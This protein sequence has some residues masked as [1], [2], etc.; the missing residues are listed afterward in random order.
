MA[1][2]RYLFHDA[3]VEEVRDHGRGSTTGMGETRLG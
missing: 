1:P 2:S 3:K